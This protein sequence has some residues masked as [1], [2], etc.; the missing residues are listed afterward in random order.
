VQKPIDLLR[1]RLG[2]RFAHG[3]EAVVHPRLVHPATEQAIADLPQDL[4]APRL[5]KEAVLGESEKQVV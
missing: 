5:P 1:R 3:V 2:E 4:L